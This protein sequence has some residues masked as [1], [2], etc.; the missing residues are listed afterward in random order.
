MVKIIFS[1]LKALFRPKNVEIKSETQEEQMIRVARKIA[2]LSEIYI[3][4]STS[5][6]DMQNG[7][8]IPYIG[9]F[10]ESKIL[11]LFDSYDKAKRYLEKNGYEVLEDIYAIGKLSK[12]SKIH[13]LQNILNIAWKL[14]V[15][16]FDFNPL[17]P[18]AAGYNIGW[19]LQQ[20]DLITELTILASGDQ[21]KEQMENGKLSLP[22]I[23]FNSIPIIDFKNPFKISEERQKQL[24]KSIFEDYGDISSFV[25]H[26]Y[27]QHTICENCYLSEF[28]NMVIMPQAREKQKEDDL[29]YFEYIHSAV[30]IAIEMDLPNQKLF[31]LKD[32]E[33]HE[34]LIKNKKFIRV[35]YGFI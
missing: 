34:S 28:L 32:R 26:Y 18:D 5:Q 7:L 12:D 13:S 8:S 30:Q 31:L 16:W 23:R 3:V 29:K 19:F 20:M 22:A 33:S 1:K 9:T 35:I 15:D 21:I 27:E 6:A 10:K 14:G 17:E 11:F 25:T 2:D 24:Q 4:L